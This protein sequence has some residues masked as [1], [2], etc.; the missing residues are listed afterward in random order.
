MI[1]RL[2]RG[3]LVAALTLACVPAGA[4][5][6]L[7]V[8]HASDAEG[9]AHAVSDLAGTPMSKIEA[10][11]DPKA[12]LRS[13]DARATRAAVGDPG[14]VGAWGPVTPMVV[15]PVYTA[16]LP[17]G[18]VL[19]WDSVG[20]RAT[21]TYLHHNYTRAGIWDPATGES[22]RIDVQGES[23]FCSGFTH[24]PNGNVI[25][26]GGNADFFLSGTKSTHIFDWRTETWSKGPDMADG[27]WYPS[28]A[29][30]ADGSALIIGGGPKVAELFEQND[31]KS[32]VRQLT[33]L[34]TGTSRDYPLMQL[35]STGKTSFSNTAATA[36]EVSIAGDGAVTFP[37]QTAAIFG[38]FGSYAHLGIGKTVYAGGGKNG[39]TTTAVVDRTSGKPVMRVTAGMNTNRRQHTMVALADGSAVVSGGLSKG[40]LVNLK[41][42]V[43]EAE[44]WNP[45]T[46]KWTRLASAKVARQYHSTAM[47][48]PDGRVF[49]GGG[50][51]CSECMTER[52]LRRDAEI[53]TPPYLYKK[54]GSGQLA[55]RP[56]I[57]AAPGSTSYTGSFSVATPNA[58]SIKKVGLVRLG[59]PTHGQDQD[60]RY[61]PL[62]FTKGAD[63][64]TVS[65]PNNPFEAPPGYYMLFIVD[66][67]GVPSVSKMVQVTAAKV[68]ST[69]PERPN[70]ARA[71][72]VTTFGSKA[73]EPVE[74]AAKLV[75]GK[76]S[77]RTD[78]WC[79][80][81]PKKFA[82]ID[83]GVPRSISKIVVFHSQAG[84][85]G[86]G[87]E[88][89]TR[90]YVLKTSLDGKD[91]SVAASAFA[92]ASA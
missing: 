2:A 30:Q 31:G 45:D 54:D 15:V 28:L 51:I 58:S 56:V 73:C 39:A 23:I 14:V 25:V 3:A 19:M 85:E 80:P 74:Q 17:N 64:L 27:R 37:G 77:G 52:Y 70:L 22:R 43:Y 13:G 4:S 38:D 33:K 8:D 75:D 81:M 50:G 90:S 20:D 48:L 40:K 68:V 78:K 71:K 5:A 32:S 9:L 12:G 46:E 76:I 92:N 87:A 24:L 62:P 11:A 91:W 36:A 69:G 79:S 29:T 83:L 72:G 55:D 16:Q 35:T 89:N 57:A 26:A 44:G 6:H 84:K 1:H 18:K 21:E 49:A 10:K 7:G 42:S 47:L 59:A 41:R 61:V 34:I 60:A 65:N 63:T 67:A 53:F 66:E 86:K 88:Y 82:Q